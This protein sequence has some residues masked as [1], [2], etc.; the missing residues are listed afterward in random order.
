M[1]VYTNVITLFC[2]WCLCYFRTST[3]GAVMWLFAHAGFN[4]HHSHREQCHFALHSLSPWFIFTTKVFTSPI[5]YYQYYHTYNLYQRSCIPSP[6]LLTGHIG[7]LF[8]PAV[9]MCM[10]LCMH[11]PRDS[12]T[13]PAGLL[14]RNEDIRRNIAIWECQTC[15]I[16]KTLN[17]S[18]HLLVTLQ[19]C[20]Y[21]YF[22]IDIA[23]CN[24]IRH[25]PCSI[26]CICFVRKWVW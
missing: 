12:R 14:A 2:F 1:R 8:F 4:P 24:E 3:K 5:I 17:C 11:S 18:Y 9:E 19:C 21:L 15:I 16:K 7:C 10:Q 13:P 20:I 22:F 25:V 26:Q 6:Q 23:Y